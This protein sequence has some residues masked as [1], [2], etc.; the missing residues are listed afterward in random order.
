MRRVGNI[1]LEAWLPITVFVIW[2]VVSADS[3]S[4][5][6]PPLSTIVDTFRNDWIF[7]HVRTDL[8]PS[9][10]RI[11]EA[12]AISV[13]IGVGAGLAIGSSEALR[14]TV[15]P[16]LEFIRA[17][18]A[19]AILPVA[20]LA[21]GITDRQKVFVIAFGAVWPILLNTIEGVRGIDASFQEVGR[22]YSFR[23]RERL[24]YVMGPA[25]LPQIMAGMR[26]ALSISI[27]LLIYAELFAA[28][29]GAGLLH[30]QRPA[31][32]PDPGDVGGDLRPV[33]LRL[34]RQPAL[35][36][37]RAPRALLAPR[38]EGV[39]A[40]RGSVAMT[41]RAEAAPTRE[42]AGSG[43]QRRVLLDVRDLT[44]TYGTGERAVHAI[45]RVTFSVYDGEFACVIGPSGC[46]K[47]TLLTCLSGLLR[48]TAGSASL[49]GQ[50]IRDPPSRLAFVFQDYSRSLLPWLS[51]RKNVSLPLR[52]RG[53]ARKQ[54]DRLT[55][56]SLEA[57]GLTRFLDH[58]PWQLSGGMQQRVA[59][60]RA[61]AYEPEILLMDEPFASVDAQTRGELEDL[62]LRVW[63]ELNVT[64]VFVTHDIDESVYLADRIIALSRPPTSVQDVVDVGLPRPRDQIETRAHP[65]FLRLRA[66]VFG[67]IKPP[68][69]A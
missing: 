12:F 15:E 61:L 6:Y 67:L 10:V 47:T 68:E 32:V 16:T 63:R 49:H 56:Q 1:V 64:I 41:N 28:H 33:A 39:A 31:V 34:R 65:E 3:S 44:K 62:I 7:A 48:P 50:L 37:V 43:E 59:I 8:V 60:A 30:P 36:R 23:R 5:Y 42:I 40:R 38:L 29:R 19:A 14:S 53:I 13:V 20:I 66:R 45:Q 22:A 4:P 25:A 51:V 9:V 35:R 21:F 55:E 54:R 18:P 69:T 11:A 52:A 26:V 58:Y 57:V 24:L 27:L 17:V 2:W 46:G